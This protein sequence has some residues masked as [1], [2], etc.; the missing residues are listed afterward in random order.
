MYLSALGGRA[1]KEVTII[2][3]SRKMVGVKNLGMAF[4]LYKKQENKKKK[5]LKINVT[6]FLVQ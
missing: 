6:S 5:L 2:T 3:E 4:F 1:G